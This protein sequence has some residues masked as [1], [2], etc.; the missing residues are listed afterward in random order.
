MNTADLNIFKI[1]EHQKIIR[2]IFS[3]REFAE[4]I[5][6]DQS[7][8]SKIKNSDLKKNQN[9]HF[10]PEQIKKIGEVYKVDMNFIFGFSDKM[11]R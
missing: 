4:S 1:I 9:Y 5:E 8:L 11:Y 2:N 7:N 6:M 3:D 10:T